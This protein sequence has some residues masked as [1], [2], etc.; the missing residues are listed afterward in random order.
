MRYRHPRSAWLA[1]TLTLLAGLLFLPEDQSAHADDRS[2]PVRLQQDGTAAAQELLQFQTDATAEQAAALKPLLMQAA[3]VMGQQNEWA[4]T[5]SLLQRAQKL[6]SQTGGQAKDDFTLT[7]DFAIASAATRV[8]N[9]QLAEQH[10]AAI[11][12]AAANDSPYHATAYPLVVQSRY[13]LGQWAAASEALLQATEDEYTLKSHAALAELAIGIGN[14]CLQAGDFRA[15]YQA[16]QC[17]SRLCPDGPQCKSAQL[18]I[19]WAAAMGATEPEAAAKLL[20]AYVSDYPPDNDAAHALHAASV[21][22]DQAEQTSAA[23]AARLQML[24]DYPMAVPTEQ[25]LRRVLGLQC[26]ESSEDHRQAALNA[27]LQRD[28]D[29]SLTTAILR[30]FS[31]ET[32]S[33]AAEQLA[34]E[35]LGRLND[36]GAASGVPEAACRWASEHQK[37]TLLALAAT[38][39]GPPTDSSHRSTAIDRI[40][41]ESL[42]QTNR[43]QE[44]AAWWDWLW[45]HREPDDRLT[46]VRAAEIAV[47][48]RES[49]VAGK[50]VELLMEQTSEST[51][52]RALAVILSAELLVR[53]ARF[54]EA[55]EKLNSLVRDEDAGRPLQ[56]RAQWLIGETYFMQQRYSEAIDAYRQVDAMDESGQWTPLALL[57]AGKAFEKLGHPRD[58]A[59]CYTALLGR[60]SD[61]PHASQ[62]QTRLAAIGTSTPTSKLR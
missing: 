10:A 32:Q 49:A 43:S 52:E 33:A 37:W 42:V 14:S 53:K 46:L 19:A 28:H 22:F 21:A 48:Y 6:H 30:S 51:F 54:D 59:I 40:L 29:G 38:D 27:L 9:W 31:D 26:D 25:T 62:A 58:A 11:L 44:S 50:R 12:Q 2:W 47:T 5:I 16:Y 24:C 61:W 36:S 45:D 13:R 60:F 41:A 55:R 34:I 23:S 4:L 7:A 17:Y 35:L 18:G 1:V 15:G 3:R 56:P 57:Q 39:L 20:L 8:Q